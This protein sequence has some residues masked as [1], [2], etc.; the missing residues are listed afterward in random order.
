MI[1]LEINNFIVPLIYK[2]F[3]FKSFEIFY[4]KK[5]DFHNTAKKS[6]ASQD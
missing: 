6:K 1:R 3:F 4:R 5:F 2:Y